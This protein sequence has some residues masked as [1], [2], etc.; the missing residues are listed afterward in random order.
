MNSRERVLKS[1]DFVEPDRVAIDFG[2]HRSSG[3]Q[4]MAYA[5]LR[6]YLGLPKR[7]PKVYDMPQ[8]LAVIDEDVLDRFNVDCIEMGRGFAT[9]DSDWRP[10]VLPN[11]TEC[12]VPKWITPV[13]QGDSWVLKGPDGTTEIAIQKKGMV[14]FDQTYFPFMEDP[15]EK[16]DRMEELMDYNMWAGVAAPPGPISWDE[17][18]MKFLAEGAKRF[19]EQTD[20]AIVGLFGAPIFEGGQQMVRMDNYLMLLA[21]EPDLV[22]R[23]LDKLVSIY[24]KRLEMYLKAVGPYIDLILFSDDYGMQTG[25]QISPDMFREFFKPRH[26]QMWQTVKKLAPSVKTLLHSCGSIIDLLPDMIEAGLDA[27]NPVQTNCKNMEPERLKSEFEGQIT[28]WGGGCNTQHILPNGTPAEVSEDVLRN[29]DI[30]VPG[31]GY[32][33]QQIHNIQA[34]VPP[35]NIVAMFDAI[36]KWNGIHS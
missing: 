7:P 35:E 30:L 31:G 4:A 3:I 10:W 13:K 8:Q 29:L 32:V 14:Y 17:E 28:F 5:R 22:H 36:A 24:M 15:E 2:A 26:A 34:D 18:G 16:I 9:D 6:D 27:V 33:F 20:R 23:F 21:A 25:P 19:R 11:G 12:L 1:M